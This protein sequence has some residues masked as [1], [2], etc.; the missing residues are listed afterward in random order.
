MCE[1]ATAMMIIQGVSAVAGVMAQQQA[2]DSQSNSNN[3]QG[4]ALMESRTQNYNQLNLQS[5]QASDA[6]GQ[7]VNANNIAMREAQATTIAQAGPSGLSVDALLGDIARKGATYDQSVNANLDRTNLQLQ[8]QLQ[9]VNTQTTSGFNQ[10]K[11][12]APVD[13]LGAGL[14]IASAT[15]GYQAATNFSGATGGFG[16][17]PAYGNRDLGENL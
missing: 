12:P 11:S 7:K 15:Q 14:K 2:A 10:M 1:P 16:S 4:A 5:Q 9:N 8:N 3:R 6:A 17:G 13:Y